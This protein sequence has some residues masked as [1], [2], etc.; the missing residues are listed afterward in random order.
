MAGG[1]AFQNRLPV[2]KRAR[3]SRRSVRLKRFLADGEKR[4]ARR[5]HE[6]FLRRGQ[7]DVQS[8]FVEA[9][10][11]ATQRTHHVG[12]QQGRVG[13][14]INGIANGCKA[15]RNSGR[16][17]GL[18]DQ[19]R[20]DL[21]LLISTQALFYR[22]SRDAGAVLDF[23]PLNI[24]SVGRGGAAKQIA[25]VA[26]HT[27]EHLVAGR[28]R[29]TIQHSQ[30]PV[31]EPGNRSTWPRAVLNSFLSP[32]RPRAEAWQ[33]RRPDGQSAAGTSPEQ[34]A[35]ARCSDRGSEETGDRP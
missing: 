17:F 24:Q 11:R 14:S 35:P 5:Q 31:P 29:L 26:V 23:Q 15:A 16:G 9:Q 25:E 27:T 28:K 1:I 7:S 12:Q 3:A 18:N 10:V 34:R 19:D 2:P 32:S 20:L 21:A 8:P 6:P 22:V 30:P 4:H 13:R 33:I